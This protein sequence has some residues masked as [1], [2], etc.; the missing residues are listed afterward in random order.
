MWVGVRERER[1]KER[2]RERVCVCVCVRV[3]ACVRV[4]P[5]VLRSNVLCPWSHGYMSPVLLHL[6]REGSLR[7]VVRMPVEEVYH[8]DE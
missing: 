1:E 6:E 8:Y 7:V 2:E 3:C 5:H 4:Y